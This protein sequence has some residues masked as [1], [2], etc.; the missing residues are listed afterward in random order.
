VLRPIIGYKPENTKV[1]LANIFHLIYGW[2]HELTSV[3]FCK[4]EFGLSKA[5]AV[6]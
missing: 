3:D 1:I 6:D 4:R 2:A 5:T